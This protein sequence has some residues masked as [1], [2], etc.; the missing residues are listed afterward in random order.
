MSKENDWQ[1]INQAIPEPCFILKM[2]GSYTAWSIKAALR[3]H[4]KTREEALAGLK[5]LLA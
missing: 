2:D 1:R 4:A 5:E 3:F